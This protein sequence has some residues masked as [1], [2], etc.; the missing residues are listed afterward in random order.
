[1]AK[2]ARNPTPAF[3]LIDDFTPEQRPD[4]PIPAF[5][6][7]HQAKDGSTPPPRFTSLTLDPLG[8]APYFLVPLEIVESIELPPVDA[9][10]L[11][12]DPAMRTTKDFAIEQGLYLATSLQRL[13]A[14]I[15]RISA[16]K[17]VSAREFGAAFQH[18]NALLYA[19]EARATRAR[20][21][22][23]G[24]ERRPATTPDSDEGAT[25]LVRCGR[26]FMRQ[27]N[28]GYTHLVHQAGRFTSA[29]ADQL[30]AIDPESRQAIDIRQ[31]LDD[32]S[33]ANANELRTEIAQLKAENNALRDS[34]R[35][36]ADVRI[37]YARDEATRNAWDVL[38]SRFAEIIQE[39]TTG[40]TT[41]AMLEEVSKLK[42]FDTAHLDAVRQLTKDPA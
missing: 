22:G 14:L 33:E 1:M 20:R 19:F 15:H 38:S 28:T 31:V 32:S 29:E 13:F 9:V 21:L 30:I 17:G 3:R 36:L 5:T 40:S 12:E 23:Y 34:D 2:S 25:L 7:L 8:G 4:A 42:S 37:A 41:A 35:W 26:F 27:H 39:H 16:V 11:P 24:P 18:A 10:A 6:I